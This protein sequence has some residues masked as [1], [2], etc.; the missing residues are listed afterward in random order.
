MPHHIVTWLVKLSV[1]LPLN[2]IKNKC[3]RGKEELLRGHYIVS[4][5]TQ[6]SHL[7]HDQV[8]SNNTSLSFGTTITHGNM[9]V[10]LIALLLEVETKIFLNTKIDIMSVHT[11]N[12]VKSKIY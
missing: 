1:T 8:N 2:S 7:W 6:T 12:S 11:I 3:L 10:T 4:P 9:K 5:N